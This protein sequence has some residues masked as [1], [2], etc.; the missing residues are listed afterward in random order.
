ML[1]D[2]PLQLNGLT[3]IVYDFEKQNDVLPVH[4]HDDQTIHISIVARGSFKVMNGDQEFTASQ[5][6]I[7][8]FEPNIPHSFTALEDNGRIVNVR[9][10]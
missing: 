3:L 2:K 4:Q 10:P 7:L 9:K 5:G 1:R 6:N 8:S